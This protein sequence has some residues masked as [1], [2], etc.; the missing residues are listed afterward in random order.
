MK[1]IGVI[2]HSLGLIGS[3]NELPWRVKGDLANFKKLTRGEVVI[4]G[5]NTAKG[6]P[7][8][9]NR[10][11]IAISSKL[12]NTTNADFVVRTFEE[13]LEIAAHYNKNVVMVIGGA[14]LL[15]SIADKLDGAVITEIKPELVTKTD[16]P[17]YLSEKFL[18]KVINE[19]SCY[20]ELE[21]TD[22]FVMSYIGFQ[23][24]QDKDYLLYSYC[25]GKLGL[26]G[27]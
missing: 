17:V 13:A 20:V 2:A 3:G 24:N 9:H 8:L 15:D 12:D 26:E 23:D 21:K 18:M 1:V 10:Y 11:V 7:K 19:N 25:C 22:E 5:S 14:K 27:I 16:S 6:L 4:C